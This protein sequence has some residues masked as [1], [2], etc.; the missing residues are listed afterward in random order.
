MRLCELTE[1]MPL[2]EPR[3][4]YLEAGL[5]VLASLLALLNFKS[6]ELGSNPSA[7]ALFA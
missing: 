5:H 7:A 6:E 2:S 4:P 1:W 3:F